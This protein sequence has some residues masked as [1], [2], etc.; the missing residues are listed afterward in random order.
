MR[1]NRSLQQ[2]A[3]SLSRRLQRQPA[4]LARPAAELR[5]QSA[6]MR[7]MLLALAVIPVSLL[8][9][10]PAPYTTIERSVETSAPADFH[11]LLELLREFSDG[12]AVTYTV[13]DLPTGTAHSLRYMR[14][15]SYYG[16]SMY[17]RSTREVTITHSSGVDN[18]R[19]RDLPLVRDRL[20]EVEALVRKQC[21][22]GDVMDTART[23]CEGKACS[24]AHWPPDK[25]LERTR[26]G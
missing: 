24:S 23:T 3:G 18:S 19:P 1:S 4:R 17:V 25:L 6:M 13:Q 12:R 2:P 14:S 22:L 11:C 7:N 21:G 5:R 20:L 10:C 9:G 15:G 16:W 26:D 8:F